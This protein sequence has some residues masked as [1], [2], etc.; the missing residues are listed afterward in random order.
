MG[1][2][3]PDDVR[4][5]GPFKPMRFEATVEDCIVSEGEIPKDL[6]GGF[7]RVGPTWK[8]PTKQ[9]TVGLLSTD[10]MVQALILDNGRADFRNRWIH[11]P[12]YVLENRHGR[13]LFEWTDG[14]WNDWRNWGFAETI[15]N[16]FTKGVPQGTNN[17]NVFPFGEEVVASGEQGGAP[18]ALDPLTL[19]TRGIVPWSTQLSKGLVEPKAPGDCAFTAHPKWDERTG[20]LYGWTYRDEEPY[21]TLHWVHPSGVVQSRDIDDAPYNSV[22]HDIWLT[23]EHVVMPFQPFLADQARVERG[24]SVLAWD[25]DLPIVV[26]LIPR[27]DIN[28]PIRWIHAEIEPQYVMHT[29]G[30]NTDG[31]T[32]TLDGPIFDRP[33][34]PFDFEHKPGD[35][36]PLF[37]SVA[38]STPGRWTIDLETGAMTSERLSDR[39]AELPKVDQRSYGRNYEWGYMVGGEYK[40]KGMSMKSLVVMNVKTC[41]EQVYTIRH[42]QPATVL[43]PTFVPRTVASAEGDGYIIVPVSRWAENAGEYLIF[44][45]YDIT[46][47]PIARIDLPFMLGW[48]PHGHWMDFRTQT[49][50]KPAWHSNPHA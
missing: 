37:F 48:T 36:V 38:S 34:F 28:G 23:A 9:G 4:L 13:G 40:R 14:K 49:K 50:L 41:S 33:P 32:L 21:V 35:Q 22:T 24:N 1:I 12:K 31:R 47:G 2:P 43:E 25:P 45:T 6:S 20:E 30:A 27:D 46:A 11:T 10:G 8:R 29:L 16:E 44:D 17:I 26:A 19:E 18:I 42:D 3:I 15:P 7:Y 39:P 5:K